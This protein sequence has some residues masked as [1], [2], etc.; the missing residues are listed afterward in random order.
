MSKN[1][2]NFSKFGEK[3]RCW[4]NVTV[5]I[6]NLIGRKNKQI[7]SA[8]KNPGGGRLEKLEN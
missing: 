4:M 8:F 3:F 5:C 1:V 6:A 2:Q 7:T